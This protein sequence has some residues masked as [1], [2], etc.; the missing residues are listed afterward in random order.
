MKKRK[1]MKRILATVC[2]E[3]CNV[4]P[5]Q[6]RP[7]FISRPIGQRPALGESVEVIGRCSNS[8]A[9]VCR[10]ELSQTDAFV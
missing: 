1:T 8:K 3:C 4:N 5:V 6:G 7:G 2:F 10:I 9:P